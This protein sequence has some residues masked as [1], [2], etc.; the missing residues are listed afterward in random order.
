M[1]SCVYPGSFDPVTRGHMDLISRASRLFD[2]VTVTIMVNR[3][4]DASIPLESRLELLRESCKEYS[5]V[6]VD[7]WSGL[8]S[9]YMKSRGESIVL[10]GIR[11]G[12]DF[13]TENASAVINRF[14]NQQIET[15]FLPA[16]HSLSCIS[17][18]MVK[19]LHSFGGD[20][21]PFVPDGLSKEIVRLLSKH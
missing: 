7:S 18:S 20:I 6:S 2:H 9:E 17:S 13:E 12:L 16:D 15:L 14:L 8:L 21:T 3:R 19:E 11:N 10:R 1:K 4:K 5:N